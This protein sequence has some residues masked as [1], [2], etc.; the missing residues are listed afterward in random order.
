MDA[1]EKLY[2]RL[3]ED[4]NLIKEQIIELCKQS[5]I[6]GVRDALEGRVTAEDLISL[7]VAS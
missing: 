3:E 6:A 5:Y 4:Q 2:E 1:Q 7:E